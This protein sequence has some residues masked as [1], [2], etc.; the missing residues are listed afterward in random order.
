MDCQPEGGCWCAE[1]PALLPVPA[2]ESA[3]CLCRSCL[4]ERMRT[5]QTNAPEDASAKKN[6][7]AGDSAGEW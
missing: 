5:I 2:P 3:G 7:E 4:E 6:S 1:L